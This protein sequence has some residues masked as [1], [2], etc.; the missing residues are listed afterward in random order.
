MPWDASSRPGIWICTGNTPPGL[1]RRAGRLP[2]GPP[3]AGGSSDTLLRSFLLPLDQ[4]QPPGAFSERQVA[5]VLQGPSRVAGSDDLVVEIQP[6]FV[7][8]ERDRATR[9]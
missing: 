4:L 9:G 7:T 2:I 5:D 8:P 1:T 3:S 6:L